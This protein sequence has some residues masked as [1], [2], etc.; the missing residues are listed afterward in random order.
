[1]EIDIKALHNGMLYTRVT[2]VGTVFSRAGNDDHQGY[3][4]QDTN[5]QPTSKEVGCI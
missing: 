5:K 4:S 1:M 2:P 3:F